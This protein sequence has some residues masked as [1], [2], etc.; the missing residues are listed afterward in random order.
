MG[1]IYSHKQATHGSDTI[2]DW[3]QPRIIFFD[4]KRHIIPLQ[5][6]TAME[7]KSFKATRNIVHDRFS[8]S[9]FLAK[10]QNCAT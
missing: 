9:H 5:H 10:L 4:S 7:V 6:S 8:L 3:L 1:I 2:C